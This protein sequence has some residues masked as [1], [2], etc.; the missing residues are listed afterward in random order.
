MTQQLLKTING[1]AVTWHSDR[2]LNKFVITDHGKVVE[3][4]EDWNSCL[5][6]IADKTKHF[7]YI[8]LD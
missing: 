3:K 5:L 1:Y 7:N 2:K 6:Y 4:F 8:H